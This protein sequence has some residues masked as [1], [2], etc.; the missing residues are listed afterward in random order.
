MDGTIRNSCGI[1]VGIHEKKSLCGN[2][3]VKGMIILKCLIKH[4]C[5]CSVDE[6]GSECGPLVGCCELL[7]KD[8]EI[9][10]FPRHH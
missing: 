5:M 1:L 10:C 8:R 2:L 3:G 9:I 6:Y 7:V 4:T